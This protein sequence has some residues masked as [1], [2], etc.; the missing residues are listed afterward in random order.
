MID[1]ETVLSVRRQCRLLGLHRSGVYY[2]PATPHQDTDLMNEIHEIWVRMPFYGYRR[3]TA[4]LNR[5][6]Y[7]VNTKRVRRLM[8]EAGIEALYPRPRTSIKSQKDPIYPYLLKD[9]TIT[10]PNQAWATDITYIKLPTGFVYLVALI[11]IASRYILAWRISNTMDVSF[12]LDMLKE[13]LFYA[14]PLVLNTDQGSQFTS[15]AWVSRV[16]Q[17]GAKV[18]MDGKGRWADNITIERFW[19]T[20]KHEFLRYV[21]IE[22]LSELR[23]EVCKFIKMYNDER[24]HQALSYKTPG[25]VYHTIKVAA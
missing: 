1:Q 7:E 14:V 12:C 9:M 5:R 18:S 8:A 13:A 25:E 10:L 22:T 24:L 2:Q 15:Q 19:R 4:E 6:G 17:A 21:F 3:L 23:T 20:V 11:D 16:L